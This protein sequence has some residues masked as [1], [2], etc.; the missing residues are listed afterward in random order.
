MATLLGRSPGAA[1]RDGGGR[2]V[3]PEIP[4]ILVHPGS[5]RPGLDLVRVRAEAPTFPIAPGAWCLYLGSAAGMAIVLPAGAAVELPIAPWW[6]DEAERLPCESVDP[7]EFEAGWSFGRTAHARDM[8]VSD[9]DKG[10]KPDAYGR[11]VIKGFD[12]QLDGRS[13]RPGSQVP[14]NEVV[15]EI[16][17]LYPEE[18]HAP[19]LRRLRT[20]MAVAA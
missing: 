15:R 1:R 6:L 16:A 8:E 7:Q 18:H 4:P 10:N 9:H 3:W 17:R 13:W 2:A 5:L 19:T 11:G 14:Y 12:D 20:L